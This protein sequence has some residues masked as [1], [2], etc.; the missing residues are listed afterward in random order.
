M[1]KAIVDAFT[2]DQPRSERPGKGSM[3]GLGYAAYIHTQQQG[4]IPVDI[5]GD[6]ITDRYNWTAR[7]GGT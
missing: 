4:T 2:F 3:C 1:L 5:R 6:E 7:R